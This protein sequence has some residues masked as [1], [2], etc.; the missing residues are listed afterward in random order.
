MPIIE[1]PGGSPIPGHNNP[2]VS[3]V[4]MLIKS[5]KAQGLTKEEAAAKLAQMK[6][7]TESAAMALVYL[8][9]NP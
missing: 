7:L 8:H 9:W 4:I 1:S 3:Q 6:G 2:E 5:M